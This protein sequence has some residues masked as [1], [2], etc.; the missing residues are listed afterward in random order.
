MTVGSNIFSN[1]PM[2]VLTGPHLAEL[3]AEQLGWVLLGFTTTVAGNLT[4]VGSVANIIVAELAGRHYQ[5]GFMEYL[6]FGFVST[7][8]VLAVG[9]PLICWMMVA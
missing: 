8:L 7:L 1:V 5:L 2:V 6:R 3:G 9:V 4:L